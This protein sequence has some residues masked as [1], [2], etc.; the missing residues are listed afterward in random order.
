MILSLGDVISLATG[1]A[2][3]SDFSTSEVSK[4]ANLAL[5]EVTNRVYHKQKEFEAV[6]NLTGTGNERTVDLPSDFDGDVDVVFYSTS[7][8]MLGVNKITAQTQL[9][10]VDPTFI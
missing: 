7:T 2:G 4:L 9:L 10:R 5:T 8:T 1:F 3:R 6:S